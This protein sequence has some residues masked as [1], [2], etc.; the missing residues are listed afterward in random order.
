[1]AILTKNPTDHLHILKVY[2]N[3]L[4]ALETEVV[5]I[6][7]QMR[8]VVVVLMEVAL[9]MFVVQKQDAEYKMELKDIVAVIIKGVVEVVFIE[10]S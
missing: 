9:G 2:Y 5:G 10:L 3:L 4:N 8:N 6:F 7:T 1:M